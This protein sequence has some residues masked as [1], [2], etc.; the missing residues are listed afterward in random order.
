M[1]EKVHLAAKDQKAWEAMKAFIEFSDVG[2][3]V[4]DYYTGEIIICNNKF[5]KL[6]NTVVSD[7]EGK[8]CWELLGNNERCSFCPYDKLI[9]ENK[10]PKLVYEWENYVESKI[11]KL[12]FSCSNKAFYWLDERLA[13]MCTFQDI[14]ERHN[15]EVE[16]NRLAF[17]DRQLNLPNTVSL[18]NDFSALCSDSYFVIIDIIGLRK[19]NEVYGR[20]TGDALLRQVMEYLS[21]LQVENSKLYRLLEADFGIL[22]QGSPDKLVIDDIAQNILNRGTKTWKLREGVNQDIY[23]P[24]NICIIPI[25][26]KSFVD[27]PALLNASEQTLESARKLNRIVVF[28]SRSNEDA[29]KKML[30]E[31]SLKNCVND[32]MK[33]F[34]IQYQPIVDLGIA[35]WTGLEALCRWD[36]PELGSVPPNKFIPVAETTGLIGKI[37]SWVLEQSIIHVKK[38]KLDTLNN[39]TLGINIS[40]LQ[41]MEE[42]FDQ[43]I[44]NLLEKH[45]YPPGMLNLEITEM[46]GI[47]ISNHTI[48]SIRRLEKTGVNIV[49]EDYEFNYSSIKDLTDIP[50]LILKT[51]RSII[52]GLGDD[53]YL[54][55]LLHIMVEFAH[56]SNIKMVAEGVETL[57]QARF[58]LKERVDYFQGYYFSE[59]LNMEQMEQSLKK[60]YL[61]SQELL[62]MGYSRVELS[63][64]DDLSDHNLLTMELYRLLNKCIFTLLHSLNEEEAIC[65]VLQEMGEALGVSRSYVILVNEDGTYEVKY[66]WHDTDTASCQQ[67]FRDISIRL[68][69][70]M[71]NLLHSSEAIISSDIRN[72]PG[73]LYSELAQRDVKAIAAFP[74]WKDGKIRGMIGLSDCGNTH[75]WTADEIQII[76]N[77]TGVISSTL[78]K[79]WLKV[80]IDTQ[81][82][83][84]EHILHNM[85]TLIYVTDIETDEILFANS[86][87]QNMFSY[88]LHGRKC[89]EIISGQTKRCEFCPLELLKSE[90][91]NYNATHEKYQWEYYDVKSHRHYRISDSIIPWS[92]NRLVHLGYAE[93]TTDIKDYQS[94]L[95]LYASLDMFSNTLNRLAFITSARDMLSMANKWHQIVT[96][97]FID[98]DNLKWENDN[99]GHAAGDA[100]ITNVVKSLRSSI[101]DNDLIGRYGGDE[102]IIAF[103]NCR[104][105]DAQNRIQDALSMLHQISREENRGEA[106]SF[107]FGLAE[108]SEIEYSE[109]DKYIDELIFLADNRMFDNKSMKKRKYRF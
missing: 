94:K 6:F 2:I 23:N 75:N 79:M 78:T 36:S 63:Q 7:I 9:D 22:I 105:T 32:N 91:G 40:L 89:Y 47:H 61:P 45:Q 102:F 15:L 43:G 18:E 4:T 30:F 58:L 108:S 16:L 69:T 28:D 14:T 97:V 87:L 17:F 103:Y 5:A 31:L 52:N 76:Y 65:T 39:F 19:I 20:N 80:E 67:N 3:Y 8:I 107:S 98:I 84:L 1:S 104:K 68:F 92:G 83:W 86:R 38:W 11:G 42:E 72:L 41:L 90:Q 66:D 33:G 74:I 10:M 21:G 62:N 12:W 55:H 34:S 35:M 57:E 53:E 93:D 37:G 81:R 54:E 88:E 99:Q 27:F 71:N 48:E 101:R 85:D 77:L 73:I 29:H 109:D 96:I 13:H 24:F 70:E 64:L 49:I 60:F 100:L 46:N 56:A 44:I 106:M 59:P 26:L 51:K 95:E 50:F 82:L 25:E